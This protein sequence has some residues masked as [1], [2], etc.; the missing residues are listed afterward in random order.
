M[1]IPSTIRLVLLYTL[2]IPFLTLGRKGIPLAARLVFLVYGLL[3]TPLWL[4]H[5]SESLMGNWGLDA[6]GWTL[7]TLTVFIL[8]VSVQAAWYLYSRREDQFYFWVILLLGVLIITF[9]SASL[10]NFYILFEISLLPIFL[11]IL[12]WGY[13][14]ERLSAGTALIF[15]TLTA[16]LP[17]L[18]IILFLNDTFAWN[19][20]SLASLNLI[21]SI[22]LHRELLS[23]LI[24]IAFLVKLPIFA[25]HQWLPK[26]HVEAPVV[27]SIILAAILLKLGGLGVYRL[28]LFLPLNSTINLAIQSLTLVGGGLIAILCLRQLDIKVLIAYSSVR[29]IAFTLAGYLRGTTWGFIGATLIMLRH[30]VCSSAL[31][32]GANILYLRSSSRLFSLNRGVLS[33]LPAFSLFWFLIRLGNM[34]APPTV[35][36][37]REVASIVGIISNSSAYSFPITLLTFFAA[38]YTLVLYRSTQHGSFAGS[39][40]RGRPLLNVESWLLFNHS[41]WLFLIVLTL[42]LM[43]YSRISYHVYN[44]FYF[45]NRRCYPRIHL[46]VEDF[47]RSQ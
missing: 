37:I 21:S 31:F 40:F 47:C 18:A 10:L 39:S 32:A 3:A 6:L 27:G 35:N 44:G 17:L 13:Q 14:P 43:V 22:S 1:N 41:S 8:L 4:H 15:Y 7:V 2:S 9:R 30:G 23:T 42:P 16:S 25:F 26:A 11:I 46:E 29:H 36:L 33:V 19:F 20:S 5:A 24:I 28:A 38:A 12:G 34:G 45:S